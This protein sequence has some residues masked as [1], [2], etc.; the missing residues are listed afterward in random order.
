[1]WQKNEPFQPQTFDKKK[2]TVT[3][4][5]MQAVKTGDSQGWNDLEFGY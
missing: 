5:E 4:S 3:V 2:K 1:M